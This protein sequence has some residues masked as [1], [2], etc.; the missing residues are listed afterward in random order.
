MGPKQESLLV[1]HAQDADPELHEAV[2]SLPDKYRIAIT[3]YYFHDL[4]LRDAANT[5][6]LAEGTM[7]SRLSTARRMLKER[8]RDYEG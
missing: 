4:S 1:S 6:G 7:K 5:L 3:L 2:R 8:L